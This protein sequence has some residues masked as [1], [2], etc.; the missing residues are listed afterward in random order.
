MELCKTYHI[1]GNHK[2][3]GKSAKYYVWGGGGVRNLKWRNLAQ[4]KL[5]TQSKI[6]L[7]ILVKNSQN[8]AQQKGPLGSNHFSGAFGCLLA[9]LNILQLLQQ[10][11]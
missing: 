7:K 9:P 2:Q 6:I 5:C 1:E 4:V 11:C 8:V 3:R 10:T